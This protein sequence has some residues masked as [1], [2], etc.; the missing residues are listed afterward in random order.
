MGTLAYDTVRTAPD[1]EAALLDFLHS[2]Y[3]A[4]TTAAGWNTAELAH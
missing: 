1:P 2:A 4:G 3:E